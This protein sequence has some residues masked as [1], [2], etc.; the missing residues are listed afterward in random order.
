MKPTALCISLILILP[1]CISIRFLVS[2]S[3]TEKACGA[4]ARR[5]I[6]ATTHI[7]A[8]VSMFPHV[9][10]AAVHSPFSEQSRRD[11]IEALGF[12]LLYLLYGELPW[13][14]IYAPNREWKMARIGEMKA[15]DVLYH[16]LLRS[17]PELLVFFSHVRNLAFEDSPDYAMLSGLFWSIMN[18]NGWQMDGKYD[19]I[20]SDAA[21]KGT[22]IPREYKFRREFAQGLYV[23]VGRWI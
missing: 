9:Y 20:D 13:Q 11:D 3:H 8:E 2:I 12:S 10:H 6:R 16:L 7:T 15:G 18:Q 17:P 19:W 1:S 14:G 4:W 21:I 5:D 22:L 23:Y